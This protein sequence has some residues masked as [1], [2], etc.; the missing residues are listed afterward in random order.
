MTAAGLVDMSK[1]LYSLCPGRRPDMAFMGAG[2]TRAR[3]QRTHANTRTH[4]CAALPLHGEVG[5]DLDGVPE[6]D[7]HRAGERERERERER[8]NGGTGLRES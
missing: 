8:D 3:A 1:R 4:L 2:C 5:T 7:R 6:V